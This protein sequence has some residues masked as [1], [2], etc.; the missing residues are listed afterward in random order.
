MVGRDREHPRRP[1]VRRAPVRADDARPLVLGGV[2]I[3]GPGGLAGHSDA[4]AV[5]ARG[6]RRAAR[7]GRPA[8]PRHAVPG[9]RRRATAT[10]RRSS[11]CATSCARVADRRLVGSRTSTSWSTP[12][13]PRLAPH[14]DAMAAEPS[15]DGARRRVR[16]GDAQAGRGHRRDRARRRHRGAGPSRCWKPTEP[17]AA[18]HYP[19]SAMVRIRDTLLRD[20][21]ELERTRSGQG[22]DV[23]VRPDRLRRRRTSAT[24]APRSCSTRSAATS[25]G[26]AS[27]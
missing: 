21:V 8:R 3:D 13:E 24:G 9:V 6:R 14:L 16:V 5:R 17:A 23:R 2:T 1:R 27:T 7:P 20:T 12:S 11:C 4:D 19:R 10:P 18:D 15:R 26:A 22:V 25:S